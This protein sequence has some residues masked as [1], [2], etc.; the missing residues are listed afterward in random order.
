MATKQTPRYICFATPI[1]QASTCTDW[2]LRQVIAAPELAIPPWEFLALMIG[3]RLLLDV[4]LKT[5]FRR[6]ND[7]Q[8]ARNDVLF[9]TRGLLMCFGVMLLVEDLGLPV[10]TFIKPIAVIILHTFGV[11]VFLL[12]ASYALAF[13]KIKTVR[14]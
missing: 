10:V 1:V 12:P 6:R 3:G 4:H 7:F 8:W 14:G 5:M 13:D 9:S 2:G 11:L